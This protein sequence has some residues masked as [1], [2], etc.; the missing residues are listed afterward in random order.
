[1]AAAALP[2]VGPARAAALARRG[3]TTRALLRA[4]PPGALPAEAAAHLRFPVARGVPAAEA[5]AV[6]AEL[7]ARLTFVGPAG[8]RRRFPVVP[9]GSVRRRAARS[10]DLDLLVVAPAAPGLLASAALRPARPGPPRLA[11]VAVYAA[12]ARRRSFVVRRGAKYYAVD[13][14]L[15]TPAEK[16]FALFHFTGPREYNIRVRAHAKRRGLTLN[17]YGLF[18]APRPGA[19]KRRAPGSAAIRTER[20]LARR[21]GVTYRPPAER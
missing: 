6:A 12:G 16:P 13:L 11:V 21:L 19:K 1:M 7:A 3:L 17:Q 18:V 8:R 4:A 10:K 14:F 5:A 9:V 20:D 2:G 15:A